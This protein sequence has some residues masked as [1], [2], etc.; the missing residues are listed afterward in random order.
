[1]AT[2][3]GAGLAELVGALDVI[4]RPAAAALRELGAVLEMVVAEEATEVARVLA[5]SNEGRSGH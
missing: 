5:E 4:A 2:E 1:V 3:D